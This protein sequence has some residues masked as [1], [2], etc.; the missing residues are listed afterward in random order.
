MMSPVTIQRLVN[1]LLQTYWSKDPDPATWDRSR[2]DLIGLW[3][4]PDWARPSVRERTKKAAA[5]LLSFED[6]GYDLP[7]EVHSSKPVTVRVANAMVDGEYISRPLT[8]T[9]QRA[10]T[11]PEGPIVAITRMELEPVA[12]TGSSVAVKGSAS[13]EYMAGQDVEVLIIPVRG[14]MRLPAGI[15]RTAGSG[16]YGHT[17]GV[18]KAVEGALRKLMRETSKIAQ[19]AMH[20]DSDVASFLQSHATKESSRAAKVLLAA[21]KASLP[22]IAATKG[23]YGYRPKT[24]ELGMQSCVKV[25]LCAGEI[26]QSLHARRPEQAEI[27][28]SFLEQHEQ[29]GPADEALY[30][31]IMLASYPD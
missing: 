17:M 22:K 24:A 3:V 29:V 1:D 6:A 27:I 19:A 7:V 30:A 18:Q 21:I 9:L 4:D 12:L 10:A 11:W 16:L 14:M 28:R 13:F 15:D 2:S 5:V 31:G 26:T 8:L 25:R 23:L 20:K